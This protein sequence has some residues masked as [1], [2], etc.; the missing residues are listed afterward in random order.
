MFTYAEIGQIFSDQ[1]YYVYADLKNLHLE[2]KG[3]RN[4]ASKFTFKEKFEQKMKLCERFIKKNN[5]LVIWGGGA[6]GI[7]FL[8][9]LDRNRQFVKYVVDINPKKTNTFVAGTGHLIVSAKQFFSDKIEKILVMNENYL[10]EIM[11]YRDNKKKKINSLETIS[12]TSVK[13]L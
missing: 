6:K 13:K 12:W 8:N 1:Y 2:L 11:S 7:T 3:S 10:K 5:N 9:L 4:G